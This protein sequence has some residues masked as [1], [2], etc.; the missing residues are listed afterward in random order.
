MN[1]DMCAHPRG[2]ARNGYL[3][4]ACKP[5]E[6]SCNPVIFGYKKSSSV[7]CASTEN[8]AENSSLSCMQQAL[9]DPPV[10]DADTVAIRLEKLRKNLSDNPAIAGEI[11]KF[12]Y[13]T[14]ACETT[15]TAM[16]VTYQDRI[17]PHKTCYGLM[18]MMAEATAT[19]CSADFISTI[20]TD[21]FK[22]L[23]THIT[24]N[25]IDA[26]DSNA[27]SS[28]YQSF[29]TNLKKDNQADLTAMCPGGD[30]TPTL[31]TTT[32]REETPDPVPDPEIVVTGTKCVATCTPP[33]TEGGEPVCTSFKRGEVPVAPTSGTTPKIE[34]I[35]NAAGVEISV[36]RVSYTPAAPADAAPTDPPEEAQNLDCEIPDMPPAPAPVEKGT[37]K[38][39]LKLEVQDTRTQ[40][41]ITSIVKDEISTKEVTDAIVEWTRKEIASD[42][43]ED[44]NENTEDRSD[45]F[46]VNAG[47][48]TR[49]ETVTEDSS[50]KKSGKGKTKTAIREVDEYEVCAVAKKTGYTDSNEECV[51]IEALDAKDATVGPGLQQGGAAP[52]GTGAVIRNLGIR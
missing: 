22:K 11:F 32:T 23:K 38:L 37:K 20:N 1:G 25:A 46:D 40:T 7:F 15:P 4:G 12:A 39:T 31:T 41:T 5:N 27:Y 34:K 43:D 16:V 49:T 14:C 24:Q 26:S 35:K 52:G 17:R 13:Q 45:R 18:N 29:L 42:D 47:T 6:V 3:R 36:V 44:E 30:R 9:Q 19:G 8:N 33:A 10:A 48:Q 2:A 28:T 51:A 50:G 21:I